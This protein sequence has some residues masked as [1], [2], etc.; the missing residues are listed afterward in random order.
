MQKINWNNS[1]LSKLCLGTVQFGI[2][3]G[4]ANTEG[5]LSQKKVNEILEYVTAEGINCF[6]TAKA[7]G[8]SESVIGNYLKENSRLNKTNIISKVSSD[9]FSQDEKKVIDEVQNSL[10]KLSIEILFGL[11]LH[12][13][14]VLYEWSLEYDNLVQTLKNKKLID[15]FGISI[16]TDE[17]F[18]LAI[19]NDNV[20]MIQIPFNLFDQRAISKNWLDKAKE[21]NKLIFIR[22]VYLQGLLLMDTSDVPSYL[23]G[24]KKYLEKIKTISFEMDITINELAL[25]FVNTIADESVVLFGCDNLEQAKE[26]I[27][28][29]NNLKKLDK[30]EIKYLMENLSNI[31]ENIYNPTKWNK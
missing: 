24:A 12:D 26:N 5:Q 2:D 18:N 16:Y 11:L 13:S 1:T 3:Y 10:E 23:E 22:S 4:I 7:Y 8:N 25:S 21:K 14:K 20:D 19:E 15:N 27:Y 6:D 28:N 9:I 31:S 30:K 17:E 29:F